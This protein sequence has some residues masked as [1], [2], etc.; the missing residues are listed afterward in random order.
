[1]TATVWRPPVVTAAVSVTWLPGPMLAASLVMVR[2][3]ATADRSGG[4]A[5]GSAAACSAGP[6]VASTAGAASTCTAVSSAILNRDP[7]GLNLSTAA[8][9]AQPR[10]SPPQMPHVSRACYGPPTPPS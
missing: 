4:T 2:R 1:V 9:A 10:T 8:I 6:A 3:P 5:R 7:G